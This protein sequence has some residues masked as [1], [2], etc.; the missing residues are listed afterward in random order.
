MSEEIFEVVVTDESEA[1]SEIQ[2]VEEVEEQIKPKKKS[3]RKP[4][5]DD[6]K[7]ALIQRLK[8]GRE[9]KAKERAEKAKGTLEVPKK[10][11]P[12]NPPK[13]QNT[14]LNSTNELKILRAE[15][16][17]LKSLLKEQK[18]LSEKQ[19]IRALIKEKEQL[20]KELAPKKSE[21]KVETKP[22]PKVEP[23]APAPPKVEP[24]KNENIRQIVSRAKKWS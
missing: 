23:K 11:P 21:P 18:E 10:N 2:N 9:R 4:M 12:K 22:E 5:T 6:D 19:E 1:V 8:E 13:N 20:K 17:E 7:Q 14:P 3:N 16:S 24:I 15:I